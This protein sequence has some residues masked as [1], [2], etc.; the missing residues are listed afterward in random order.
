MKSFD[1]RSEN[2]RR[3]A[4]LAGVLLALALLMQAVFGT[5]GFLTVQAKHRELQRLS[6]KIHQL[7]Q[8]NQAL[9]KNVQD[10]RSNPAT[11]ERYA[12]EEL[13]M[14]KPGE[15]IYMLPEPKRHSGNAQNATL[16]ARP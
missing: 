3:G 9:Q 11:I 7:K 13:H 14:A 8:E 5:N 10:L 6:R 12:R 4:L 1:W 2:F 16:P 15:T